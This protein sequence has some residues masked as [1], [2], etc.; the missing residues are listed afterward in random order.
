MNSR[1]KLIL[2]AAGAAVG[3]IVGLLIA[4]EK[5]KDLRKSVSKKGKNIADSLSGA[6][7]SVSHKINGL[8]REAEDV[9]EEVSDKVRK[10][11]NQILS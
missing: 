7:D 4:P 11:S 9:H 10:T 5:G 2:A 8:K 6:Y 3:V 1:D